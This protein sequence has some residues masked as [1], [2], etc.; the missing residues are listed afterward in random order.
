MRAWCG[1]A[2]CKGWASGVM[3]WDLWRWAVCVCVARALCSWVLPLRVDDEGGGA[4]LCALQLL[5]QAALTLEIA[6]KGRKT[7]HKGRRAFPP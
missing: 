7:E 4:L 6:H 5:P 2:H 1:A 3:V